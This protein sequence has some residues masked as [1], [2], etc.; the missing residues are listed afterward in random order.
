MSEKTDKSE[1]FEYRRFSFDGKVFSVK[2]DE[3]FFEDFEKGN[4]WSVKL[5]ET[6]MK[7]DIDGVETDIPALSFDSYVS[8][9]RKIGIVNLVGG[10]K[11]LEA[12]Y[13]APIPV[14]VKKALENALGA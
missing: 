2:E 6:T 11:R 13:A 3:G 14:D 4:I 7:K 12:E 9:T 1:P 10:V 8:G 5:I